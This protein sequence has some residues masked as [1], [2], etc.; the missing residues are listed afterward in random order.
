MPTVNA[1]RVRGTSLKGQS[2]SSNHISDFL[3]FIFC[4]DSSLVTKCSKYFLTFIFLCVLT[5]AYSL[6]TRGL[7]DERLIKDFCPLTGIWDQP[8]C[9]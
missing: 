8:P 9:E 4:L 2:I 7:G 6:Y 3:L 1:L 5:L